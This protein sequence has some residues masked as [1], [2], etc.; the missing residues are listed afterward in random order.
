MKHTIKLLALLIVVGLM[1]GCAT[2]G[3]VETLRAEIQQVDTKADTAMTT[4][5]EAKRTSAEALEAARDA[6][7]T[8]E[9][10]EEKI[11]RMFKKAMH[12]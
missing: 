7:A 11:D 9:A 10:T 1:G 4:A 6:K 5:E 8:S 12:K 3:D 2:T